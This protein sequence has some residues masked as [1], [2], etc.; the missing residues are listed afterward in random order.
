M[1][2]S[3]LLQAVVDTDRRAALPPTG[4]L[5]GRSRCPQASASAA[6]AASKGGAAATT[7]VGSSSQREMPPIP[8]PPQGHAVRRK[9]HRVRQFLLKMIILPRQARDRHRE[10]SAQKEMLF[11]AGSIANTV[12]RPPSE[13]ESEEE[14]SV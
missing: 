1:T 3:T 14:A 7:A 9:T 2:A 13:S 12:A 6:A 11:F 8:P 10:S 4:G 5:E